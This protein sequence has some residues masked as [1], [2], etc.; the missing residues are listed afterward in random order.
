[1]DYRDVPS[2]VSNLFSFESNEINEHS[3]REEDT[4]DEAVNFKL[5]G[6]VQGAV[7]HFRATSVRKSIRAYVLGYFGFFDRE[8]SKLGVINGKRVIPY[9]NRTKREL[10]IPIISDFYQTFSVIS[11]IKKS[12]NA[13]F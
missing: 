4:D 7:C 12:S 11:Y 5:H 1:M 6:N 10:L 13:K 8:N 3:Y 9:K 2:V